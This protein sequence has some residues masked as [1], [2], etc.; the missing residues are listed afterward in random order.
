MIL[1]FGFG[2]ISLFMT[3][4]LSEKEVNFNPKEKKQR[5]NSSLQLLSSN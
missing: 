2:I 3:L 1:D 5:R 4:Q